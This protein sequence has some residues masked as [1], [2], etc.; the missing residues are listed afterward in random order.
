M[1]STSHPDMTSSTPLPNPP[2]PPSEFDDYAPQYNA[3][4]EIGVKRLLGP[5]ALLF[6]EQ[7]LEILLAE[8]RRAPHL[9]PTAL[10]HLD[11]GCGAGD[12]LSLIARRHLGWSSEGCD[13]SDGML[14]ETRRRWGSALSDV[15]L[16]RILPDSFPTARFHLITAVCVFHHIPPAEWIQTLQRLRAA[17]LPGGLLA[18]FE[19]NPWNPLTRFIVRR[20][21]IDQNA[22]LLSPPV[23]R[24][25]IAAAGFAPPRS[26]FFL[27]APPRFKRLWPAEALLAHIPLG[28]QYALF[29]PRDLS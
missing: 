24:R 16:W 9:P 15:P 23:A 26:R 29:A 14:D 22:V 4:M 5:S 27:F 11:F 3:G 1:T 8:M 13:I 25:H 19:H 20:T 12:F 7:K 17:L 18:L 10:R 6:L 21:K 2:R 28:G